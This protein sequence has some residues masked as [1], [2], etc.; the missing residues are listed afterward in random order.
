[1]KPGIYSTTI[2]TD[3]ILDLESRSSQKVVPTKTSILAN[4]V[5]ILNGFSDLKS[6]KR[7]YFS[8][9]LGKMGIV[10]AFCH[11]CVAPGNNAEEF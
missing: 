4:I 10:Y 6:Y 5:W 9:F 7:T 3:A 1:M 2:T 11:F 8:C